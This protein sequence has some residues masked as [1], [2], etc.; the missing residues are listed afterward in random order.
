MAALKASFEFCDSALAKVDDS[1]LN[2]S[3]TWSDG[4]PRARAFASVTLANSWADHYGMAAMYLRLN[5]LIPPTGR[6]STEQQ[7]SDSTI[8]LCRNWS[9]AAMP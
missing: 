2:E 4:K 9:V 8:S 3:I 1:K 6:S 7:S 5:G